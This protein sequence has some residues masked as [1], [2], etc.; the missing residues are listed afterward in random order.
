MT[1]DKAVYYIWLTMACGVD[2]G[3]AF[4]VY[5]SFNSIEDVY[6]ADDFSGVRLPADVTENLC[7][8]R[9]D[10][11]YEVYKYCKSLGVEILCYDDELYPNRLRKIKSPP[12]V[13][14]CKGKMKELEKEVCVAMVGTRKATSHGLSTAEKLAEGMA[15]HGA[16]VVS[17]LADGIDAAC[18][19]G[20][21]K[22]NGYTVG[23]IGTSIDKIY[24][25][26]NA[27]LY[28]A[29][30]KRGLVISEYYPKCK[31]NKYSYPRRNR[32]ISG[33]SHVAVVVEAGYRSGALITAKYAVEQGKKVFVPHV[34]IIPETEGV[35]ALYREGADLI[36]TSAEVLEE[37]DALLPK[38]LDFRV[39]NK[40]NR[41]YDPNNDGE[42]IPKEDQSEEYR[43]DK[44][45]SYILEELK[46]RQSATASE[47]A[48]ST[49]E[50]STSEL[51]CAVTELEIDGDIRRTVG[52]RY[53]L[54]Y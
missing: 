40:P 50:F 30:Y 17:G 9:L 8:K 54:C 52:G 2:T 19:R 31:T 27:T 14:Y 35:I 18:H 38:P 46:N 24:P 45:Q 23:V 32:I 39:P 53:E 16:T 37:F 11:A 43:R 13:L 5:S 42:E 22:L 29:L 12:L 36:S 4:R 26:C 1:F 34:A 10:E 3:H 41:W 51:L 20:A 21:L 33:L 47:L 7:S 6:K 48:A 15:M 25:K 28:D 44:I 49:K